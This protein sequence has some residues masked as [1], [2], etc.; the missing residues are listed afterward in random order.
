VDSGPRIPLLQNA[1]NPSHGFAR[2]S[3]RSSKEYLNDDSN[4]LVAVWLA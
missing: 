1:A 3:S 4:R 2:L